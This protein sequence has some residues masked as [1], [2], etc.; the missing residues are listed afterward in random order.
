MAYI[1]NFP[2]SDD[3]AQASL[4]GRKECTSR[5]EKYGQVG[6]TFD[7]RGVRFMILRVTH[8]SLAYV[9]QVLYKQEGFR[10]PDA[11]K[12]K[13]IALHP[14]KKWVSSQLV[15]THFYT[16]S[17]F[18]RVPLNPSAQTTMVTR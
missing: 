13:W 6:D 14:R 11:F 5:N 15:Y 17:S 7:I 1:P 4:E 10:S 8:P 16:R 12:A 2:F 3:M 9:M 18:D